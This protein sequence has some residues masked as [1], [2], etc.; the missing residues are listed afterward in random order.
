MAEHVLPNVLDKDMAKIV[1]R[2]LEDNCVKIILGERIEEIQGRDE[3]VNGVKT[4][5][6]RKTESMSHT[7]KLR[8]KTKER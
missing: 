4:N 3:K 5:T 2:E 1:Q 6:G 8:L 7:V